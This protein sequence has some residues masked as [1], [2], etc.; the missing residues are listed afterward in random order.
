MVQ[1]VQ[2]G[3][4]RKMPRFGAA[5]V[6]RSREPGGKREKREQSWEVEICIRGAL[7][8]LI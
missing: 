3:L 7:G 4:D 5:E 8:P 6:L 1:A 2:A